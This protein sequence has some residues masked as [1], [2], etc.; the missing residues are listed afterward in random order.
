MVFIIVAITT[1]AM[2]GIN[3]LTGDTVR[4]QAANSNYTFSA[5]LEDYRA[6]ALKT[7]G[8]I[9]G[10]YEVNSALQ[11]GDIRLLR[12][13]ITE[14]GSNMDFV[15]VTDSTG[16]VLTSSG[17]DSS[18]DR[19]IHQKVISTAISTG[20]GA[21]FIEAGTQLPL[22]IQASA[23]VKDENN[24]LIAIISSGYD[25]S[26][27]AH[28]DKIKD[29]SGCEVE[30]FAGS[31]SIST[32]F[33]NERG[34]RAAGTATPPDIV[35]TVMNKGQDY[36]GRLTLN[37]TQYQVYYSPLRSDG[38]VIGMLFNGVDIDD[39]LY[40]QSRI[41]WI[42]IGASAFVLFITVGIVIFFIKKIIGN[43]I[44]NLSK[45]V[46]DVTHGK[47]NM[48]I[49][50]TN[51]AQDEIGDLTLDVYSLIDIIK[52]IVDDLTSLSNEVNINGDIDYRI[53]SDKYSGS[54]KDMIDDINSLTAGM[55]GDI[56]ELMRGLLEIAHG[57]DALIKKMP[58]KKATITDE[59]HMLE[60]IMNT[61]VEDI[62]NIAGNVVNGNLDTLIDTGKY[63]GRWAVVMN[64]LNSIIK[65]VSEPITEI[66]DILFKM[67]NGEFI[68][69][70]G[71]Y[72]GAFNTVKCAV[73]ETA[74]KTLSYVEEITYMLDSISKGDLTVRIQRD[75]LGSYEPIWYAFANIL[76]SL[77]KT[78]KSIQQASEQ[79]HLG[80][81]QISRI[82]IN[83]AEGNSSQ[84]SA[85]EELNASVELINEKTMLNAQRAR[86][87]NNLSQKSN[88][89]AANSNEDMKM[90]VSS[91][92]SIRESSANISKIIKVIEDIAF[93][94]NLLALNAAVEAARAGE[95]GKGF[96]VVADEVRNLAA[97]SQQSAKETTEQIEDSVSRVNDGMGAA[98]GTASSLGTIVADIR[99]IS[100]LIS[101][102][103]VMSDEQAESF[104]QIVTGISQ[105]SNVVNE[106][107]ATSEE[108]ASA[109]QE[110]NAQAQVLQQLISFFKLRQ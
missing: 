92:E 59:F 108:C 39:I 46:S 105:I 64:Q 52:A 4:E 82:A 3:R 32:T 65:A 37:G 99:H 84:S 16:T 51:M 17:S 87:A 93:Q 61:M 68:E 40:R 79:V 71:D 73:N 15:T 6:Y 5:I 102:I 94:T 72:K 76:K 55:V 109:S 14:L 22:A 43:P 77:N 100:E 48:N 54:Y 96:T 2:I 98:Q 26:N 47:T 1:G 38:E 58:G 29:F 62:S 45:L 74:Q 30:L 66:E 53:N 13:I 33:Y 81:S 18:G 97:K 85:V 41:L 36:T 57:N 34:E 89:N 86:E 10:S 69:M 27:P 23:I 9:A 44:K 7:A 25:L 56:K 83:L 42:I 49:T 67:S 20:A 75:Y 50:R 78:M 101:Q 21:S 95:H 107:S 110:L 60:S 106:N 24:R 12:E 63:Q 31:R 103:T 70:T 91:M 104:S 8:I 88:E 90:M 28:V 35:D 80:A 19:I 11:S